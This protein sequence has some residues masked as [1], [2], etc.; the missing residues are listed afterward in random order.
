MDIYKTCADWQ[1]T[2]TSEAAPVLG[3]KRWGKRFWNSSCR[4]CANQGLEGPPH[5]VP[6]FLRLSFIH[7][8]KSISCK[9]ILYLGE[10]ELT[11]E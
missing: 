9:E 8:A 5:R 6:G 4:V 2:C 10:A 7:L 1:T 3:K 11:H